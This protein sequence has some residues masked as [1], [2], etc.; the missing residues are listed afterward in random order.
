MIDHELTSSFKKVA[1]SLMATWPIKDVI[2]FHFDPRQF[3]SSLAQFIS[4]PVKALRRVS[5]LAN[6]L[7]LSIRIY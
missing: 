3:S 7:V 5:A 4:K 6:P 2:L 1:E